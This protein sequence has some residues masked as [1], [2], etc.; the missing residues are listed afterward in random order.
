MGN[1]SSNKVKPDDCVR[2]EDIKELKRFFLSSLTNKRD[3]ICNLLFDV[4]IPKKYEYVYKEVVLFFQDEGWII[5]DK[6]LDTLLNNPGE[7]VE[8]GVTLGVFV[9]R[10]KFMNV[11]I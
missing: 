9:H 5:W 11:K 1:C 8:E 4:K 2:N 7:K 10:N 3:S 6:R